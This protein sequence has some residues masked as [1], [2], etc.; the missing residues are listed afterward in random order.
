MAIGERCNGEEVRRFDFFIIYSVSYPI[1]PRPISP[2]PS[3]QGNDDGEGCQAEVAQPSSPKRRRKRRLV[4][5]E[6]WDLE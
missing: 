4:V 5:Y 6:E 3:S 2:E 1:I